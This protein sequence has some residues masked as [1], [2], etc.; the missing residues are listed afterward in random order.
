MPESQRPRFFATSLLALGALLGSASLLRAAPITDLVPA[1]ALVV[2]TAKPYAW[3]DSGSQSGDAAT[4]QPAQSIASILGFLNAAGLIPSEGQ[5]FADIAGA[6]PLLGRFE[7]ALILLDVSCKEIVIRP[8]TK[9]EA[10]IVSLRLDRLQAAAVFRTDGQQRAVVDQLNRVIGRYTNRDLAE[11]SSHEVEGF[12]YQRL[13]DKRLTGWAV[14]EWGRMG[15][16]YVVTFGEG[17]FDKIAAA[18]K[19]K[20][21]RLADSKWFRSASKRT[22]GEKAVAQWFIALTRLR[23]QLGPAAEA[24][25][26]KVM[27]ALE[28]DGVTNDLWTIGVEGRALTWF[29]CY[30][31]D[32]KNVFHTYS[33][34]TLYP[35]HHRKIIPDA[36]Q[37]LAVINVPTSW[38]VDNLPRAWVASQS[39]SNVRKW[40]RIWRRLEQDTG[41]DINGNLIDHLGDTVILFDY[42]PHPLRVPFALTTAIEINDPKAVRQA[43]DAILGAWSQYLDERAERNR[44]VLVRVKVIRDPDGVWFL[45]AGILGP[46]LT[47]TDRYLVLSWSPQALRDALTFIE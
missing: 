35:P 23:E 1:E 5:V 6:L 46:A 29:R 10:S 15:D 32:G 14:W 37:H 34:P 12:S 17:A 44:T 16:F 21:P 19:S 8:E 7:H 20:A 18:C 27:T 24:R 33:D 13:R 38:L 4:T 42:P 28:A 39:P 40:K 41:I 11:L 3:L 47:V 45:Q 30:E 36:A 43:V 26:S 31:R 9:D 2:Y 25:V 22:R